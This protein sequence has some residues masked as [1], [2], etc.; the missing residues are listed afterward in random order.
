MDREFVVVQRDL[1]H[2]LQ[3]VV[4]LSAVLIGDAEG[5]DGIEVIEG[6]HLEAH[7]LTAHLPHLLTVIALLANHEAG[8]QHQR[9]SGGQGEERNEQVVVGQNDEGR[10][11]A[12]ERDQDRGQPAHGVGADGAGIVIEAVDDIAALVFVESGPVAVDDLGE[13]VGADVVAD[14][15]ADLQRDPAQKVFKHHAEQGAAHHDDEQQPELG[16]L[17][18]DD[19]IQGVL[20]HQTGDQAEGRAD[21]A[22]HGIED[23]GPPVALAVGEDPAPVV[24]DLAEGSVLDAAAQLAQGAEGLF[25]GRV[26][27]RGVPFRFFHEEASFLPSMRS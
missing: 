16:G 26:R 17:L 22:Q 11:E 6:F 23:D 2:L 18:P 27:R 5:L 3:P 15:D 7:H 14:P 25:L 21:D 1:L 8:H 9:R 13:D 12:V 20:C 19:D 10:G 4:Q 24:Q